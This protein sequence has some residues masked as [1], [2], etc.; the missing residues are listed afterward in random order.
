MNISTLIYLN[1]VTLYHFTKNNIF[2]FNFI[3]FRFKF[4]LLWI[5]N[6]WNGS[7]GTIKLFRNEIDN[8]RTTFVI[9]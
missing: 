3:K 6:F 5:I 7:L 1:L 8:M 9:Y 4:K 2:T